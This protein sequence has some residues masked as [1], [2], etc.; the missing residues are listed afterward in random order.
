MAKDGRLA[1]PFACA[2]AGMLSLA[3][4]AARA[5]SPDDETDQ[6]IA[7]TLQVQIA[8]QQGRE[9]MINGK[10]KSAIDVLEGQIARINGNREYLRVL[11]DAYRAYIQELR[12]AKRDAE[13]QTYTRRMEILDPQSKADTPKATIIAVKPLPE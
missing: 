6:A 3:L 5:V 11:R 13:V 1:L 10:Y 7:A 4:P 12:L 9:H 2:F 8:L